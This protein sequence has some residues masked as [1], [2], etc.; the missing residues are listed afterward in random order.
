MLGLIIAA[1]GGFVGTAIGVAIP[2]TNFIKKGGI[3]PEVFKNH[4]EII[5]NDILN[6]ED[7]EEIQVDEE[8]NP[9]VK[10]VEIKEDN[11]QIFHAVKEEEPKSPFK[12]KEDKHVNG[13][14]TVDPQ[15]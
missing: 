1:I 2:T 5:V 12:S 14:E 11:Q 13:V 7:E 6:K 8:G 9:I 3:A 4:P 15:N 10:A